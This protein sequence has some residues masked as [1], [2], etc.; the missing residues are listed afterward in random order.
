VLLRVIREMEM[1]PLLDAL[2]ADGLDQ[3]VPLLGRALGAVAVACYAPRLAGPVLVLVLAVPHER[4]YPDLLRNA[5]P[6]T[7]ALPAHAPGHR[8]YLPTTSRLLVHD[9]AGRYFP[10]TW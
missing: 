8:G 1:K 5:S 2:V 10:V 6:R 7:S 3:R 9:D 4:V